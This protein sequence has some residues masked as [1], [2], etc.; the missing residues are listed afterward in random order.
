MNE[1]AIIFVQNSHIIFIIWLISTLIAT[2]IGVQR[3]FP[4]LAFINGIVLGPLGL[5]FV[6]IQDNHNRKACQFCAEKILKEAKV[7][8]HCQRDVNE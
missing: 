1:V 4:F 5:F 6:L 8:P 2:Y 3:G 7:C